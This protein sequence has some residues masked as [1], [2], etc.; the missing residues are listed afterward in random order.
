MFSQDGRMPLPRG[1]SIID[2]TSLLSS[3]IF[4]LFLISALP[5]QSKATV[6][7]WSAAADFADSATPDSASVVRPEFGD[8]ALE[9]TVSVEVETDAMP[10]T[11]RIRTITSL[12]D[13]LYAGGEVGTINRPIFRK[14]PG[15]SWEFM[16]GVNAG[17]ATDPWSWTMNV[18]GDTLWLGTADVPA[19][20]NAKGI[21]IHNLTAAEDTFVEKFNINDEL[22]HDRNQRVRKSVIHA[23][24]FILT[25]R[26]RT[27]PGNVEHATLY[28]TDGTNITGTLLS[29]ISGAT[30]TWSRDLGAVES[31]SGNLYFSPHTNG[32]AERGDIG[33]SSGFINSVVANLGAQN[34]RELRKLTANGAD[35]SLFAGTASGNVWRSSDGISWTDLGN[36]TNGMEVD[37]MAQVGPDLFIAGN[38]ADRLYR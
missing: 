24:N 15:Q 23:G 6:L 25:G 36:V 4:A 17:D 9:I 31:F 11:A 35:S 28:A 10:P 8:G 30:A 16:G 2:S 34:V 33:R 7:N 38:N 5:L 12:S 14:R 20:A 3:V 26:A 19:G 32:D 13:T 27:T 18:L 21:R 37:A 22:S 1:R 29:G